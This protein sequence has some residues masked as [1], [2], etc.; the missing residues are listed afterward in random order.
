MGFLPVAGRKFRGG[1]IENLLWSWPKQT[2]PNCTNPLRPARGCPSRLAQQG[3]DSVPFNRR[4]AT[5]RNSMRWS[6]GNGALSLAIAACTS[7]A[8]R[9]AST[10]LANSTSKPSPVALNDAA[11]VAGDLRIDNLGA[12]RLEPAERPFLVRPDQ[13]R[14]ARYI[15]GEDRREPTFD[16]TWLSGLHGASPIAY[17][18]TPTSAPLALSKEDDAPEAKRGLPGRRAWLLASRSRDSSRHGWKPEGALAHSMTSSA[19]TVSRK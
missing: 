3:R 6:S 11:A 1:I 17:D 19:G 10:T 5:I 18:P 7:A 8:Q 2:H 14:V 16:A 12:E 15:G 4:S 13:A 9:N